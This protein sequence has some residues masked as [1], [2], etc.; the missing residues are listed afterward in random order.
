M[1]SNLI[2]LLFLVSIHC[3]TS[4]LFVS[5]GDVK[6]KFK[7]QGKVFSS[8]RLG[9]D[10]LYIGSGDGSLYAIDKNT[11]MQ[12]WKFE[13]GGPVDSSPAIHDGAIYFG[14]LDGYY[15]AID[16]TTGKLKWKFKTGGEKKMGATGYWGMK[17]STEYME[18]L[19]DVFLSSPIVERNTVYFGSSDTHLYALDAKTGSMKWKFKTNG[20]I[21]STPLLYNGTIYFGSW[22]AWFYAVDAD[23]GTEK[24]KFKT[25]DSQE[26]MSGILA[27]AVA[28]EGAVYFG[29]RDAH[30]YAISMDKGNL[31]WKYDA[32]GAWIIGTAVVQDGTL[33]VGTSDS[34]LLLALNPKTGEEKFRFKTTGYVFDSPA[35]SGDKAYVGDF[36]G[37][38]YGVDLGSGGKQWSEFS[39]ESRKLY[40]GS[41][42]K[43]DTLDF[44]HASAGA[45]L[46][47]Y[48]VNK[49][50]MDEFFSLG[51]I[52]STPVVEGGVLFFGSADGNVYALKVKRD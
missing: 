27:S 20:V 29:A 13:T 2:T 24:W 18:D 19:W 8:P 52:V 42:L 33:Y 30:L 10:V 4:Q 31:I 50:V 23:K 36:T 40:A 6:W 21:H 45:D 26:M 17:P 1:K 47:L 39:T 37:R 35:L 14:S 12:K 44:S 25:G 41:I 51:S 43:N 49:K 38:M 22:D 11:G 32:G 34:F 3:A 9:H 16:E 28:F 5:L 15:Y 48:S 7:T 46:Y